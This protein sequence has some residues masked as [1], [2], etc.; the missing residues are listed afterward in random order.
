[1]ILRATFSGELGY[2][3]HCPPEVALPV[4]ES[5]IARGARPYGLD[6]MDILRIEK[7]YLTHAELNGQTTPYDLG[8]QPLMKR[9]DDFVGRSL[10]GR[11]A[12]HEESRPRLVGVRARDG[13]SRFLSG[14][15]IVLPAAPS[16]P[17][18]FVTSSAFSPALNEWVGLALVSRKV[19]EEDAIIASD[20]LHGLET[21]V[22]VTGTV[23][24][25]PAGQRMRQ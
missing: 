19:G 22:R 2:E 20:P 25:D 18:G 23:H 16:V 5:L 10:L 6:A 4:W 1:M 3:L 13:K 7:G 8:M 21:A 15:Q 9:D 17:C 11:P 24:Y 12:F 14:A